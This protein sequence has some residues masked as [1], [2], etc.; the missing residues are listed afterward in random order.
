VG[1]FTSMGYK[2]LGYAVWQGAK[3]YFR[4]RTP[5]GPPKL[6]L[7]GAAGA[8]LAIAGGVL[9]AQRRAASD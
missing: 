5:D 8:A 9:V 3:W 7:V 6:A 2:V 1:S 4:R